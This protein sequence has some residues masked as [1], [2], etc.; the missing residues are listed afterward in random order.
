MENKNLFFN[1]LQLAHHYWNQFLHAKDHVIDATCGNGHD[2]LALAKLV[3]KENKGHLTCIDIQKTAI[4]NTKKLLT[5]HLSSKQLKN[6]DFFL[7]SHE[8]FPPHLNSIRLIVYNLGYLPRGNKKLTTQKDSTLKSLKASLKLLMPQG[9][10]S[11]MCYSR[12]PHGEIEE[13]AVLHFAK[14]LDQKKYLICHHRYLNKR[15]APSL[16][17]IQKIN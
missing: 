11:V 3:L 15:Y 16:L 4:E 7:R 13:E 17:F 12:H 10:M 9:L 14:F 5:T 6:I 8:T 2:S 1:H